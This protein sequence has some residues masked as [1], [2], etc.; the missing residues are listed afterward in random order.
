MIS[1]HNYIEKNVTD[2]LPPVWKEKID[3]VTEHIVV[4]GILLVDAH[5][6]NLSNHAN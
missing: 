2:T 4:K 3:S 6:L 5:H 1:G